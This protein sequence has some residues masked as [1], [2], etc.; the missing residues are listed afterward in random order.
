MFLLTSTGRVGNMAKRTPQEID[1]QIISMWYLG[2]PRPDIQ[3]KTGVS[4][5]HIADVVAREELVGKGDVE[6]LRRLAKA[7]GKTQTPMIN[8]M[9]YI[10]F[11]NACKEQD[12]DEEDVIDNLPRV[13]EV[14]K[15]AK[16]SLEQLPLDIKE[17]AAKNEELERQAKEAEK[18]AQ[19]ANKRRE[20]A[21]KQEKYSKEERDKFHKEM[22][23]LEEDG[24]SFD[25]P[26]KLKNMLANAERDNYNLK[27]LYDKASRVH[28]MDA[29][30]MRLEGTMKQLAVQEKEHEK[31]I[32]EQQLRVRA[33]TERLKLVDELDA[34][35]FT[36]SVL[37]SISDTVKKVA[38]ANN[39]TNEASTQKFQNDILKRY[40]VLTGLDSTISK[41]Q[42]EKEW[43]ECLLQTLK[44]AYTKESNTI[45]SLKL[46]HEH[47]VPDTEVLLIHSLAEG[48]RWSLQDLASKVRR[49]GSIDK[50]LEQSEKQVKEL[51]KRKL[52]LEQEVSVLEIRK[53]S[54]EEFLLQEEELKTQVNLIMDTLR[55]GF[56]K[57][58]NVLSD[59]SQAK[60]VT[61][62]DIRA[63]G[64]EAAM[65]TKQYADAQGVLMWDPLIRLSKGER[66]DPAQVR[67]SGLGYEYR[68]FRAAI[69]L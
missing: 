63:I 66:V 45:A 61:V 31:T 30:I 18:A 9:R 69:Q 52:V 54:L 51:E 11:K 26:L 35:N 32:G 68:A 5:G 53:A 7:H 65:V 46:L 14:C 28:M 10:R 50:A 1:E 67:E 2:Y 48:E 12:L 49:H 47:R 19:V 56:K 62:Q 25:D 59:V 41:I 42:K 27:I 60:E 24:L 39:T 37:R 64:R 23:W 17:R 8:V 44:M 15:K 6:A 58:E 13:A 4:A 34:M 33:N 36:V 21:E 16:I 3:R 55:N 22:E 20:E 38:A 43:L 57:V 40:D 29:E